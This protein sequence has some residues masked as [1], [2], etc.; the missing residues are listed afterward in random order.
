MDKTWAGKEM[1]GFY[2]GAFSDTLEAG[3][4]YLGGFGTAESIVM[5]Q[6]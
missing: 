1:T 3:G 5:V 4:A 6:Q 2:F